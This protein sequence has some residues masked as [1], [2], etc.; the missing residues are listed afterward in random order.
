MKRAGF[1]AI[2]GKPNAGKSTLLNA[3]IGEPLAIVSP[4]PETTRRPVVG[5][6]TTDHAQM[7]FLDTPGIVEHPKFELHH[8][9]L[10]EIRQAIEDADVLL[11]LLDATGGIPEAERLL[12][13]PILED[14]RSSGKPA[15]LVL[16]KMDA[17]EEKA[18]AL[19]LIEYA[20]ASGLFVTSVAI[21]AL[22]GKFLDELVKVITEHLP[23]SE[24]LYDPEQLSTQQERFFV[25]EYVREQV[26]R[27]CHHE[28]P[29]AVEVI[30]T[31]FD[32]REDAPWYIAAE[33]I[34]E[35][36]SQKKILIGH[37]GSMI[38]RIGEA[39]R[40]RIEAHLGVPVY[41]DL[42]VKVRERWRNNPTYLRAFGYPVP[43]KSQKR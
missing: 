29:Y 18:A 37:G 12:A 25:A 24:F 38:K 19:P 43:Q 36:H 33:L 16:T 4:K 40:K 20:M 27:F 35:R 30:V 32:E 2:L 9:M 34:V 22:K 3:L 17:L 8:Q 41:L 28:I 7:V 6:L 39:A 23:E 5:I 42:Y 31:D 11:V 1:V 21:S 26:Y 13:E 14:V 10:T 15:I